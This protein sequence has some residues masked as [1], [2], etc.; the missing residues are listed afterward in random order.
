MSFT[1]EFS[2]K[3]INIYPIPEESKR[4]IFASRR[5]SL[6]RQK[7][8]QFPGRICPFPGRNSLNPEESREYFSFHQSEQVNN[9]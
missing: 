5:N 9:N 3:W 8:G 6:Y 2:K 1:A 4:R 7:H